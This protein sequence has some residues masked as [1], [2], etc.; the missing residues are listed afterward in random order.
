MNRA[1]AA[2]VSLLIAAPAL[3]AVSREDLQKALDENPD[4]VL[5][6]LQKTDKAKFFEFVV[7]AQREYQ[8]QRAQEEEQKEKEE[9]EEAF[10]HPMKPAIDAHTRI[11]GDKNAPITLVEYSDFQCPFCLRGFHT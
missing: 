1:L 8:M 4:L 11:R 3:A 5:Q 6:A 2:L 10:K 7:D 9:R